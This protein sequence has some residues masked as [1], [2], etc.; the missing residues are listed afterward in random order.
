MK[1]QVEIQ[2]EQQAALAEEIR[3]EKDE[4][5]QRQEM[6]IMTVN[7]INQE[8]AG[9]YEAVDNMAGGNASNAQESSGISADM[10]Q[11]SGFCDVLS[12]A[13]EEINALL[14][15]LGQNN[16]E[17]VSIASQT[18]LLALN[19]S[20]EAARAGE[21]GR[22]FAVVADEINHLATGS[23]DTATRS[24]HSQE[25]IIESIGKILKD[26]EQLMTTVSEINGRIEGLA[27]ATE[28]IAASADLILGTADSVK[29]RLGEL[30]DT[31]AI[32]DGE[33]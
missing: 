17:V 29:H 33:P 1:H 23:R 4:A 30:V 26:T 2:R 28:E 24:N 21:A 19:A 10:H 11:V 3:G 12:R 18:N 16:A 9:L 22:G 20:I 25:K 27:A 14:V 5:K 15:E 6:I 31:G 13:M 8:F 7:E 32:Q